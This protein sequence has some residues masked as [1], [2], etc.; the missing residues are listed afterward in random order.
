MCNKHSIRSLNKDNY[1]TY[2][3]EI[4]DLYLRAFTLGEYAQ[5]ISREKAGNVMD[6]M[7]RVGFGFSAFSNNQ[8]AGV[9]I[10]MPLS[11]E[12]RFQ[13]KKHPEIAIGQSVYISEV[14]VDTD[15]RGK[16]IAKELINIFAKLAVKKG[17]K[18]IVIRVWKENLPALSLYKKMGFEL[19]SGE[20]VQV[21][22]KN[23]HET[24]E[25]KKVYLEKK[26]P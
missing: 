16:G 25:M 5:Y 2:R 9:I 12:P 22:W 11:E 8:L 3:K 4:I 7:L 21:K 24:F 13:P 10:G 17:Y 26:I 23:E 20:I 1:P 15:F 18:H 14:M 6:E 19:I